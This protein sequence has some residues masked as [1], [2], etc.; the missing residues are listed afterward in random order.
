MYKKNQS[1]MTLIEIMTAVAIVGIIAAMAVVQ[2]DKYVGRTRQANA[3]TL[4]SHLYTAEKAYHAEASVYDPNFFLIGFG[5]VGKSYYNVGFTTGGYFQPGGYGTMQVAG[6]LMTYATLSNSSMNNMK[7]KWQYLNFLLPT[8]NAGGAGG[9]KGGGGGGGGGGAGTG[10]GGNGQGINTWVVR[11]PD[12]TMPGPIGD[13][14]GIYIVSNNGNNFLA[15][16]TANIVGNME[17]DYWSIDENKTLL[18]VQDGLSTPKAGA[19]GVG[20]S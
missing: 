9:K 3:K 10:L 11:G 2:V 19:T 17:P 15:G 8:A 1:G 12:G 13:I 7:P 6:D 14:G 16:A 5:A 4:L 20:G 18:N